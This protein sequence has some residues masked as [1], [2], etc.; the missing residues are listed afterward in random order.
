MRAKVS[1][2]PFHLLISD[3]AECWTFW[4]EH[5]HFSRVE[6]LGFVNGKS[7]GASGAGEVPVRIS[8]GA[9]RATRYAFGVY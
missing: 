6:S 7:F 4:R 3:T 9:E 2:V 5:S 1:R 8:V